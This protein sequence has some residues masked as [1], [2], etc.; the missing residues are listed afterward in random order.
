MLK[1]LVFL[2]YFFSHEKV[3]ANTNLIKAFNDYY[4]SHEISPFECGLNIENFLK[5]VERLKIADP[6]EFTVFYMTSDNAWTF[7]KV[8]ATASRWGNEVAQGVLF[9]NFDFHVFALYN[10]LVF[11]FHLNKTPTVIKLENYLQKMFIPAHKFMP[12]GPSYRV[13]GEGPYYTPEAAYNELKNS[14]FELLRRDI[15]GLLKDTGIKYS[16]EQLNRGYF[17]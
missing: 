9:Q 2:L 4:Y 14:K 6:N 16:Y 8:A 15:N 7:H 10:D 12:F 3:F 1:L 17:R 13:R 5:K 11:D